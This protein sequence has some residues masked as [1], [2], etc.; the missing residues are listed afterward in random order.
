MKEEKLI[1]V[2]YDDEEI[3]YAEKMK[4]HRDGLLHRAFSVF[5]IHD[6]K[7]LI[8]KRNDRKYHSGGLW[9]NA[10]CSHPR[11]GEELQEAVHRRMKEE[12]GFDCEVRELFDFVY[13]TTFEDHLCEYEYD[14]VFLGDYAGEVELNEEEASE[15]KWIDIAELKEAVVKNPE[16]FASRF[17]I[18]LQKVIREI[19]SS[20]TRLNLHSRT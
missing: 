8:Q 14:H 16:Q 18:A 13:R 11:K 9:A 2:N 7:M 19:S 20:Q 15:I 17:L 4:A 3:G 12:L 1:L 5:I 6:G 10:C